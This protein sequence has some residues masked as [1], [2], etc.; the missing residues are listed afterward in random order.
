M[1]K[2]K[3]AVLKT[4]PH[5]VLDDYCRLAELAC[6]PDALDNSART[7]IKDNIS[8]HFLYPGA[9]TT[10]WQMEGSIRAL[11]AMGC[12]DLVCVQNDTVVTDALMGE[13]LNRYVGVL[14]R[15]GVPTLYNFR[16]EDIAWE[17]YRP[18]GKMLVLDDIFPE[19]ITIP[20][21]FMGTNIVHLPT[22]KTHI[23]TTTTGAMKNAFGGLLNRK[24]HYTHSRI[25]ETLVDLLRIQQE[26]H[27]GIFALVDGTTCGSGP[28]PRTM[29]PV[30][31]DLIVAGSDSV[32]VDAVSARMMG[33]DPLRIGYIRI[34]H[35]QG[36]GTGDPREIEVVGEDVSGIDMQFPVGDNMASRV[37]DLFW[38]SPLKV[39]Q[40]LLFHTPLVYLFVFGSYV[41]HD[42]LWYRFRGKPVVK[43][44]L[45]ESKW[46]KLFQQY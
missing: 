15:Y 6:M 2:S 39:L 11:R 30:E 41:Y 29:V 17:V 16:K 8:W 7:I 35:E 31:A 12:D 27:S 26:I 22:V 10:P 25:H 28:G 9:N 4:S 24:R 33:F 37:G 34:A 36:L 46:G 42:K 32:A 19:G 3:V 13:R 44:W 21:E 1:S 14:E 18:K 23:Y 40:R 20:R 38:F 43:R 5:T 45:N